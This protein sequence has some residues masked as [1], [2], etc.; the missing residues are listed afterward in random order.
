MNYY[1]RTTIKEEPI[2]TLPEECQ[3]VDVIAVKQNA[4]FVLRR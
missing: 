2:S 1:D 3:R 4:R